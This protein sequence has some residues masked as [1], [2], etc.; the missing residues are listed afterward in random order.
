MKPRFSIVPP[1]CASLL[2]SAVSAAQRPITAPREPPVVGAVPERPEEAVSGVRGSWRKEVRLDV[3]ADGSIW[4][5]GA[6]YKARFGP[7]GAT[8]F[9]FFGSNAPRNFPV[10][11]SL[12]SASIDGAELPL[13]PARGAVRVGQRITITRGPIDEVYELALDQ[14]E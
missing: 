13:A 10:E 2:A 3:E 6:T 11:P 8:Y 14:V 1:V 12:A 7:G 9:P 5:R 4:A